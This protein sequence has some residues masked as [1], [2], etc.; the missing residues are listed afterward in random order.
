MRFQV[1]LR[2][3]LRLCISVAAPSPAIAAVT[4]ITT[5]VH[6]AVDKLGEIDDEIPGFYHSKRGVESGF[7]VDQFYEDLH[8]CTKQCR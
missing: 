1:V 2:T 4:A 8:E 5:S 6:F 3:E 7:D